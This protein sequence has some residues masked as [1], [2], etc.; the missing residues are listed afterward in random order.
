MKLLKYPLAHDEQNNIIKAVDG[1]KGVN[2]HCLQCGA[3]MI[4]RKSERRL[5]RPHF[6]HK[7]MTSNCTPESVLHLAFKSSLFNKIQKAINEKK[8]I[9][10]K[11]Q[12]DFCLDSHNGDLLKKVVDAKMEYD[13]GNFKPD[14][15]LFD[16][17]ERLFSVLEIVVTH[18]PDEGAKTFYNQNDVIVIEF[19]VKSEEELDQLNRPIL[20]PAKVSICLHPKCDNCGERVSKKYINII[21]VE[22]WYCKATMKAAFLTASDGANLGGPA[23]FSDNEIALSRKYGVILDNK[24][25]N[26]M[27][28]SYLANVCPQCERFIGEFYLGHECYAYPDQKCYNVSKIESGFF[29]HHC[30][31][32]SPVIGRSGEQVLNME[33]KLETGQKLMPDQI[34]HNKPMTAPSRSKPILLWVIAIVI[35]LAS[36]VFQRLTGPTYPIAGTSEIDGRK[37]SYELLTSHETSSDARMNLYVPDPAITGEMRWKRF[38]SYDQLI[39]ES[40]ARTGDSLSFAIPAQPPAGKVIYQVSLIDSE[41]NKHDLTEEPVIIRFK[42]AVPSIALIPHIIFMFAG[43]LYATRAGLEAL[44]NGNK[45]FGLALWTTILL[46][47]GGLI[48]GPIV[49]KY[50]FGEFWTGWPFGHDLT[51]TKTMAVVLFWILSIWR[52]KKS[53]SGRIWIL[54][55]AIVTLAI[56]L[57]PHSVLGSELDYTKAQP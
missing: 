30:G 34:P 27:G 19:H 9:L 31:S 54:I 5:K 46:A 49:Q 51:D 36:V 15:A 16:I 14:I 56:Y 48:F 1:S 6:G 10:M 22:C 57:I 8:S 47:A 12:C 55:A 4:L 21:S 37:I 42:G 53:H 13:T 3:P 50:A 29:C 11:W 2:Y 52:F 33:S 32:L 44:V 23:E 41:G 18:S 45:L 17:D 35:T 39:I 25:S 43:M 20:E 24:Y 38:K 7:G 26:T 40:L 28:K